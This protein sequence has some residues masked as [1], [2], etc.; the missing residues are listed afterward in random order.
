MQSLSGPPGFIRAASLAPGLAGL[1][2]ASCAASLPSPQLPGAGPGVMMQADAGP[3]VAKAPAVAST[4]AKRFMLLSLP[5]RMS[6]SRRRCRP[7]PSYLP[8]PTRVVKYSGLLERG[9]PMPMSI[10]PISATCGVKRFRVEA[11]LASDV[12]RSQDS[13]A[14]GVVDPGHDEG[15]ELAAVVVAERVQSAFAP[16]ACPASRRPRD[17]GQSCRLHSGYS[18]TSAS[19][20]AFIWSSCA[21]MLAC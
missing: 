18:V 20:S 8:P 17:A 10:A 9:S 4:A 3:A 2:M 21:R 15:A 13:F 19:R 1:W 14:E 6:D 7:V 5:R 11:K 12:P 16:R